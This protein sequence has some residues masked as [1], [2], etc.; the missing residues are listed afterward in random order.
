[1]FDKL[2]FEV[3]SLFFTLRYNG[4]A[5]LTNMYFEIKWSS[6]YQMLCAK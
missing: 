5:Y 2:K 3:C 1:M 4:V 6:S